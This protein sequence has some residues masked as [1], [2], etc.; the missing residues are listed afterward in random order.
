MSDKSLYESTMKG[1][2]TAAAQLKAL[3]GNADKP[4]G[5]VVIGHSDSVPKKGEAKWIN[6]SLPWSSVIS[7][8]PA[9]RKDGSRVSDKFGNPLN[10][11]L[12]RVPRGT[13]VGGVDLGGLKAEFPLK[14]KAVRAAQKTGSVTFG[15]S[16]YKQKKIFGI[17][18]SGHT[19]V[20]VQP[21]KLAELARSMEEHGREMRD[22]SGNHE[23]AA[24]K[25]SRSHGNES[26]D[27]YSHKDR[28]SSAANKPVRRERKYTRKG[29]AY[30]TFR[31]SDLRIGYD[32][33]TKEPARLNCTLPQGTVVDGRDLSGAKMS[34][35]YENWM[36]G[37]LRGRADIEVPVKESEPANVY[38]VHQFENGRSKFEDVGGVSVAS[39]S[40]AVGEAYEQ[41]GKAATGGPG[42]ERENQSLDELAAEKCEEAELSVD[43]KGRAGRESDMAR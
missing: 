1:L 16:P 11:V 33:K 6:I 22:A 2:E 32:W 5:K 4:S 36:S 9:R 41:G 15:M 24:E 42:R 19:D 18:D 40:R 21:N 20:Y 39:L 35:D 23:R 37:A 29:Y 38:F 7:Y 43:P 30:I 25:P 14:E 13:Q 31:R 26:R 10:R 27:A 3:E 28:E 17:R 12:I 34:I 8:G